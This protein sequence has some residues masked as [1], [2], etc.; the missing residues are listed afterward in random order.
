MR[1]GIVVDVGATHVAHEAQLVESVGLDLVW[2]T[3]VDRSGAER[4]AS[5]VAA[6]LGR[7]TRYVRVVVE[8]PAVRTPIELAEEL[9]VTD[10]LLGGRVTGVITGDDEPAR[11][12]AVRVVRAALRAHPFEPDTGAPARPGSPTGVRVT[13]APAQLEPGIWSLD[14]HLA[15][16]PGGARAGRYD[17]VTDDH[18]HVDVAATVTLLVG[19]RETDGVDIAVLRLPSSEADAR[20]AA[21][22]SIAHRVRPQV[23]LA[24]LPSGLVEAWDQADG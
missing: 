1:L 18:G 9:A 14:R 3:A 16:S 5:V 8:M 6:T 23:Q 19:A 17:V 15:V 2:I 7:A 11:D 24:S 13:P 21:I 20:R 4:A 10:L 22:D 12:L